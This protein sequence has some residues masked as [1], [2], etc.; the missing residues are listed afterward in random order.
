MT[1]HRLVSRRPPHFRPSRAVT[2]PPRSHAA[3]ACPLR[4]R[5]QSA[6][7]SAAGRRGAM[8]AGAVAARLA[9]KPAS[10]GAH[11]WCCARELRLR[12]SP[13]SRARSAPRRSTGTRS[14][15]PRTGP[16]QIRSPPRWARSALPRTFPRRPPGF[17][18]PDPQQGEPGPARVHAVLAAGAGAGR[19]AKTVAGAEEA[20]RRGGPRR[21]TGWRTGSSSRPGRIGP[22]ACARTGSPARPPR[23]RASRRSSTAASPAIPAIATGPTATAPRGSRR[24]FVS[25]RSVRA[26]SGTPRALPRP[27]T[28]ACPPTSKNSSANS[29]GAN[30]AVICCSTSPISPRATCSPRSTAFRGST[31]PRPCA[32]GSAARPAIPSSMP[33]CANSGTPA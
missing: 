22:A 4:A 17:A 9:G 24:I 5:R 25:A 8:V 15:R 7:H 30:S 3:V 11:R 18:G 26:R 13:R 1:R 21:A 20:E 29:A 31:M 27:S 32:P 16:W 2:Q 33:A 10:S 28:L 6:G 14:R 19:S 23:R 12:S